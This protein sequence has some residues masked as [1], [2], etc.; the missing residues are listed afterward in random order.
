MQDLGRLSREGLGCR[1]EVAGQIPWGGGV[2]TNVGLF[3]FFFLLRGD[4]YCAAT[5]T[6]TVLSIRTPNWTWAKPGNPDENCGPFGLCW[7]WKD[8]NG[9]YKLPKVFQVGPGPIITRDGDDAKVWGK[10]KDDGFKGYP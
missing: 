10:M 2:R 6:A 5:C 8:K 3:T 7:P 9:R 1:S 4:N